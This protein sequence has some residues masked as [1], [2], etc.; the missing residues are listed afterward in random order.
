[1]P[2]RYFG[3]WN[4]ICDDSRNIETGSEQTRGRSPRPCFSSLFY[5]QVSWNGGRGEPSS[6]WHETTSMSPLP[7]APIP[8]GRELKYRPTWDCHCPEVSRYSAMLRLS[9][10]VRECL[11]HADDCAERAKREPNPDIKREFLEIENRWLK[12]ACSYELLEHLALFTTHNNQ[13]RAEL[14]RR[15]ARLD[16]LVSKNGNHC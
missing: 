2:K 10:Q 12:Q 7:G 1:M 14:S 3:C 6:A 16:R 11:R 15:L 8:H 13:N 5:V 9:E 4:P